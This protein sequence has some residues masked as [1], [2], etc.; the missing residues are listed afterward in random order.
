MKPEQ[1]QRVPGGYKNNNYTSFIRNEVIS[2]II[3]MNNLY[4]QNCIK[5]IEMKL[6]SKHGTDKPQEL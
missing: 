1:S 2:I 5:A 4:L 3:Q 6:N